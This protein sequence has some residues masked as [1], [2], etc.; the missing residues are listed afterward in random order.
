MCS[1]K[2]TA[3]GG[4]PVGK[5]YG[6]HLHLLPVPQPLHGTVALSASAFVYEAGDYQKEQGV[7]KSRE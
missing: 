2:L 4:V 6:D 7:T 5:C 3:K 1:E